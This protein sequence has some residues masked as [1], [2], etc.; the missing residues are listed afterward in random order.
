MA[1]DPEE[2]DW[3][4]GGA[5]NHAEWAAIVAALDAA[6]A[7]LLEAIGELAE[8]QLHQRIGDVR[9]RALG[10][11]V[12]RYIT[13]HGLIQHDAYHAGQLAL[14]KRAAEQFDRE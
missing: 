5:A 3:P 7:G 14:L 11:G 6:N 12:S 4:A 13:L 1:Q 9:D 8:G 2:G 10:S